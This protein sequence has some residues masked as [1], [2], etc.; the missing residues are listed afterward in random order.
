MGCGAELLSVRNVSKRFGGT[1]ALRGVCLEGERGQIHTLV[2]ENGAGKSTLIRILGGVYRPDEGEILLD[3]TPCRFDSPRA[4]QAAGIVVIPQEMRVVHAA[5]VAE[6][7]M[8]GAWPTRRLF[9]VF[10]T[11][12]RR[13]MRDIAAAT[14][15]RLDYHG[16]VDARMQDLSFAE[17]QLVVIAKA[18]CHQARLLILDE[19]T[20][21]LEHREAERLFELLAKL[22]DGGV[23]IIYVSH[24]MDEIVR[25]SDACTVM[26]DGAVVARR[27][28]GAIDKD[29][30]IRLMTGRDLGE[31]HRP[32]RNDFGPPALSAEVDGG[33]LTIRR[34]QVVGLAGLLGSGTTTLLRRLYGAEGG[35][36]LRVSGRPRRHDGPARAIRDGIGLV[37]AERRLALAM[38]LCIRDNIILPHLARF[39]TGWWLDGHAADVMVEHLIEQLDIRPRDARR[40]V[41]ML[42]GGNQQKVIFARWLVG[43]IGVLLLDEPTQ[44]IDVA[45]KS[46]IHKL[47]HDFVD[48]GGAILFASSELQEVMLMSDEV[49]ALRQ[50]SRVATLRR[51]G[52][53][54]SERRLR[55]VLGG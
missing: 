27:R 13:R 8:L 38:D 15:A 51:G 20:A 50:G 18:L 7:I 55:E 42:S 49:H 45:A 46:R 14:L 41:R 10:P 39:S 16:S 48:D 4:A 29:E 11:I 19:P 17:R 44:G 30:I 47:M 31:M 22:R 40:P 5:T 12:D 25:L 52:G 6:N 36:E 23:G 54:Y 32:H 26:R 34:G 1:R 33:E 3:G 24:R 43:E 35:A 37:P 9:G 53:D 2:G 21:S 28:R